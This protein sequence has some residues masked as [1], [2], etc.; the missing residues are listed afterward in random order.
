MIKDAGLRRNRELLL[1]HFPKLPNNRHF[2]CGPDP[3]MV[4]SQ[5][6]LCIIERSMV[7]AGPFDYPY[8]AEVK[9]ACAR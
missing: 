9:H 7:V 1:N 4:E 2:F 8:Y 3:G 5:S 6:M